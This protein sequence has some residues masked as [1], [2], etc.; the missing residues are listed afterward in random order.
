MKKTL[1]IITSI[2][3]IGLV[4]YKN[5]SISDYLSKR[6][7]NSQKLIIK[8]NNEY[9]KD[10]NFLYVKNSKDYIPYS[11]KDLIDIVF[12]MLN[13]GWDDF[14]FYCPSE[15]TSCI[16]DMETLTRNDTTLA[17][18]NNFVHPY[19]SYD[20]IKTTINESGE[21]NIKITK[22][23][24]EDDINSIN[25]KVDEI[26]SNNYNS[27]DTDNN[28]LKR[29]HDYII[30]NVKYDVTR[31]NEGNSKYRSFMAYGPALEGYATCNGYADL[32]AIILSKLGY[33]N[34]KVATTL[35]ELKDKD[36]GHI[37]NAVKIDNKWLHIDLTW[38]DPVSDDGKDYL[39]HKYFL[40]NDEELKEADSGD[41]NVDEHN[42]NKSVYLEFK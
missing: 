35:Y 22:L 23:Y 15:Y 2:L 14:T 25:K 13:N 18:V 20:K 30:N 24:T 6:L 10:Y 37:W 36:A 17:H 31:N 19:N 38:D 7:T 28:N 8:D 33:E 5:D 34:F 39:Y 42:F 32:M 27:N 1:V 9:K 41:V 21:I 40:V 26:I 12:S 29:I 16:S 4:I 3:L 11:E